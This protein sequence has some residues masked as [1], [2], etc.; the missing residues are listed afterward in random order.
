MTKVT[1]VLVKL[2][3]RQPTA[4]V[5]NVVL[6]MTELIVPLKPNVTR[7]VVFVT[8]LLLF[9]LVRIT[10]SRRGDEPKNSVKL[11]RNASRVAA[12]RPLGI[13]N[14]SN[15]LSAVTVRESLVAVLGPY[16]LAK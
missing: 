14:I 16:K 7:M 4:P 2:A 15:K 11:T 8:S 6:L 1:G 10:S 13:K 5:A 12:I 9:L 3:Q